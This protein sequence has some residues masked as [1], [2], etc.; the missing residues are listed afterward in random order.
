M[1][2]VMREI[3]RRTC[4]PL[5]YAFTA[6]CACAI[7][8]AA[9]AQQRSMTPADLFRV[10]QVGA[11]TWA[12]G[13]RLAT[14]EIRRPGRWLAPPIPTFA[15]RVLDARAG[16]LR[17]LSEPGGTYLG[18]F[19]ATWS[20]GGRRLAF[21]SV[22]TG[23]VVR[24]WTW[25]VGS[26]RPRLLSGLDLAY[27]SAD[28]TVAA[29]TSDE[30]LLLLAR[31]TGAEPRGSLY[32]RVTRGRKAADE[33]G[34]AVR[35][36]EPSVTVME[37]GGPDT[38]R[39]A[40]RIVA[41]DVRTG[42]RRTLAR[43][44]IHLP[45]LSPDRRTLAYFG[46][47]A[48]LPAARVAPF[49]APGV[50]GD[51]VYDR[52]NW[53]SVLH[54]V[55][56]TTG[57]PL[58][59]PAELDDPDHESLLWRRSGGPAVRAGARGWMG[60]RNGRVQPVELAAEDTAR[61]RPAPSGIPAP[62]AGARMMSIAPA[63]DAALFV[64]SDPADG[65]R[66][67]LARAAGPAVELWHGNEWVRE[68]RTGRAEAI[69]YNAMDGTA[70]TG[71]L[72]FPPGHV[73]GT[74]IPVVASVYPGQAFTGAPPPA[75][76]PLSEHFEHPQLLA[77]LGYG[78]LLPGMP[79]AERPF[80]SDAIGA[81]AAGVLPL[82]DTLVAR[83]IADPARIAVMGQSSGGY[84]ALGLVATTDRFRTAIASASYSN[85]LSLYGTFYGQHRYGDAGHPQAGQILRMLQMER[86]FFG[87]GAPPWEAPARY[88][89]NSPVLRAARVRA[90]VMLVHGDLDFIPVQQ[91]EEF[92][93]A[94][95]RQDRRARLVRYHGEW[96]T[97]SAR[98]NVLDMWAR[99]ADWLRET[100]PPQ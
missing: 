5:R 29:W 58:A 10:E 20:P 36:V 77:A 81:L 100:M 22:D 25:E 13:G 56:A 62:W 82:L 32:F 45:R 34:R 46:E 38:A 73:A 43:G 90:P 85:L 97:I 37:S 30:R 80:Q 93:T 95:Y 89:D 91:A 3:L 50:D 87:A 11:A 92:F 60:V 66:L 39:A 28:R 19:G 84:A 48:T 54:V 78:V 74:R 44:H 69:S 18:F 35:G 1:T 83:G 42:A 8:A 88:L 15:L 75:L 55:D 6:L 70:L 99:I 65:T 7:P 41:L 61:A 9:G 31:D 98:A 2:H 40:S 51:R 76:S 12:P 63:R 26:A 57:A 27:T 49:F 23:G 96:H 64:A 21:L 67:W 72:L 94:L 52:L 53:G 79:E 33:W 71:W 86:G 59:P 68:I 14:V 24:P 16:T 4:A 47:G 17:T